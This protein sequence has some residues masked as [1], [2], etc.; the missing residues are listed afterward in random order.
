MITYNTVSEAVEGLHQRGYLEDFSLAS[1]HLSCAAR[2]LKFN[3]DEFEV[4]ETHRFEGETDPADEAVVYGI[5][6]NDGLKGVM[7][8]AYGTYAESA[9]A[10]L[11]KK[12]G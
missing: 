9:S 2:N 11:V 12:L 7:V 6:S 3:P 8:N 10:E 4:D 1:D 5:S